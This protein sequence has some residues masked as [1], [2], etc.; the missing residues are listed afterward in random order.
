MTG[1]AI[2]IETIVENEWYGIRHSGE[3]PEIA[4]YSAFHY[5]TEDREG[6]QLVL[7]GDLCTKLVEAA[8]LRYREIVLRD[9][10][11]A[12]RGTAVYRGVKRSIINWYRFESFCVRQ[13]V[14]PSELRHVTAAALVSFLAEEVVDVARCRRQSS[15]NCTFEELCNFADQLGL[16]DSALP[17]SI[18]LLCLE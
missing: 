13:S 2:T 16:L 5:L 3:I 11:H 4:L 1:N 6:P 9:L 14:D 12:N 15:L 8:E 17:D 10:K 18:R 7:S